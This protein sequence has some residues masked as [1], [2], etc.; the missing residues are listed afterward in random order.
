M[1]N[2]IIECV[3]NFSEGKNTGIINQIT[4]AITAVVGAALLDVDPGK[5]TNRTVVTFVGHPEAVLEAAFQ[6]IRKAAELIDMRKHTG[7]HPRMGATDVC[8]LIPISGISM[9]ETIVLAR[10]LGKRVAD[11]LNIPVYLYENAAI[12]VGR[13]NLSD[14]RSGEYEGLAARLADPQ[15]KP[16][17][18]KA[19]FNE[20]SG[21]TVIGA[22]DFL[23]AY[24]VNLNTRSVKKANAVA[25][26]LRE[27]GRLKKIKGKTVIG[28]D[29]LPVRIP[30]NLRFVR[31]IGWYIEEYGTAQVSMNLT[32]IGVTPLHIAF[33][34]A[35]K[36]AAERGMRVTGS[37]LVGM[38]PLKCLTDAG[39]Y[40]LHA[41]QRSAGVSE[42]E[43]V[44]TAIRSLGLED[45]TAFDP[46]KKVI[47]YVLM[48]KNNKTLCHLSLQQFSDELASESYAPGGGSAS[49]FLGALGASLAT[50][51]ANLS[52]SKTGWEDRW[53]E[54]SEWAEKGQLLKDGLLR[55]V[56]E[57][58]QA[59]DSI[60][61]ARGLPRV[62]EMDQTVREEAIQEALKLAI[63]VPLSIMRR[64]IEIFD[65][66]RQMAIIGNPNSVSDAGV[67]ALCARSAV[68]GGFLNVQINVRGLKEKE[69]VES[70]KQE[71]KSLLETALANEQE[72]LRIVNESISKP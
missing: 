72:I 21:A 41:Q 45:L 71:A 34:E 20:R 61:K 53:V 44:R 10:R 25:F 49:A 67:A 32:N 52:A 59:F 8:P 17:F 29:G 51:V 4:A 55:M 66:I 15:W 11:E 60:I 3:P 22:R 14:I 47:E 37:E 36:K 56:D 70:F 2:A 50:M 63:L 27:N 69:K 42:A 28:P 9:E 39:K 58:T 5:A 26:D 24:N 33:Q 7:E 40:F 16:D 30:G 68:Y 31:A 13:K 54:F 43:L 57:D 46:Q 19:L 65:L 12:Q 64:S 18:G 23:V 62:S 6:S 1:D 38:I 48:Q 35:S